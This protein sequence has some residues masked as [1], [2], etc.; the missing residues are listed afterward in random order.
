MVNFEGDDLSKKLASMGGEA[1]E[2]EAERLAS[3]IGLPYLAAL[4][5]VQLEALKLLNE[6]EARESKTASIKLEKKLATVVISDPRNPKTADALKKLKD[7]GFTPSIYMVSLNTLNKAFEHYKEIVL[8]P[9]DITS[10]I[11]INE[12]EFN[13]WKEK[14]KS[15]EDVKSFFAGDNSALSTTQI[16]AIVFASSIFVD[17]SDV[18]FE[19]TKDNVLLRFRVDGILHDVARFELPIYKQILNRIKLLAGLKINITDAPQ[20]GRFTIK[21]DSGEIEVRVSISPSEFGEAIVMRVLNPKSIA[22]SLSELGL[23]ADDGEIALAEIK[24]PNGMILVTG[25]TGSGK[26]TTLYAFLKTV[27]DPESKII[28]IEDPIEYHLAGIQQTQVDPK[29][30]YTFASGLR[31]ILR[32]DPD[33][34]LVGE[35]RDAETADIAVNA[36]L[37]GH[38]VFS[39]LH[40]NNAVGAIPR[41]IDLGVKPT[42]IGPA[43]SLV[44]AQRLVRRLCLYCKKESPISVELKEKINK[45]KKNLPKKVKA[46]SEDIKIYEANSPS[47]CD[48]CNGGYKGRIGIYE[49]LNFSGEFEALINKDATEFAIKELAVKNGFIEMQ[50]DGILK[51][52]A[53]ITTL[54]EVEKATGPLQW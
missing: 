15:L 52:L 35:I 34:L 47:G 43:L 28:T 51:A 44:I 11:D 53:G 5:A 25:P 30:G 18:H 42:L 16:L 33:M 12:T 49:F 36:S 19:S 21:I 39:T 40:T 13:E 14:F 3:S 22:L 54:D 41:L 37:T 32:Q 8:P 17:V 48:K 23:R 45:F 10:K 26:T 29:A 4:P 6:K 27:S 7:F 20:D 38:L 31:S 46:Y 2:R 50:Q 9:T 1:E 24:R